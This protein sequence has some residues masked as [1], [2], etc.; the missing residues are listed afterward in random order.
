MRQHLQEHTPEVLH[1]NKGISAFLEATL[2][3]FWKPVSMLCATPGRK[4]RTHLFLLPL[5]NYITYLKLL[6]EQRDRYH[7]ESVIQVDSGT[8]VTGS[9][10][11]F[12]MLC[13]FSLFEQKCS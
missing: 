12:L 11:H 4:P 7:L 9:P 1:G 6:E 13:S 2:Y 10:S 8:K 5:I 3:L